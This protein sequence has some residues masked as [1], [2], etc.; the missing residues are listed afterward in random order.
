MQR[1]AVDLF[2]RSL[3][4]ADSLSVNYGP[5]PVQNPWGRISYSIETASQQVKYD[6]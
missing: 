4:F 1:E 6:S 5:K 2:D 3:H